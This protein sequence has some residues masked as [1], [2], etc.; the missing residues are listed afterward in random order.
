MNELKELRKKN[1]YTCQDMSEK[2][3]IS[4][5]FYL[6]IENGRRRLSYIMAI[7]IAKIFNLKPDDIFYEELKN[8]DL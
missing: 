4:K 6:Q 3:N 7:K 5:P 8:K 1:N 2:L